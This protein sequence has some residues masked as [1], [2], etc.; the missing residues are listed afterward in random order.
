MYLTPKDD[1]QLNIEFLTYGDQKKKI[2]LIFFRNIN[3]QKGTRS[4]KSFRRQYIRLFH[5]SLFL[6]IP[7]IYTEC[8]LLTRPL[9]FY[10]GDSY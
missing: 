7:F 2:T 6:F 4:K 5:V 1:F 3:L 9:S 10:Q 8:I